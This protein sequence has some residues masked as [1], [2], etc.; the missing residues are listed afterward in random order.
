MSERNPDNGIKDFCVFMNE[1]D[2][3]KL[4]DEVSEELVGA[5]KKLH[6]RALDNHATA[7][8]RITLTLTLAVAKDGMATIEGDVTTKLPKPL[9]GQDSFYVRKN[10]ALSRH[11]DKQLRLGLREVAPESGEMREAGG[12]AQGE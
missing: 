6:E 2:G 8:G 9:R 7:K 10:G 1:L 3:G 4:R 11:S 5:I 12:N